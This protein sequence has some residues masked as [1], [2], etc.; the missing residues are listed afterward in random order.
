MAQQSIDV[1]KY[2]KRAQAE[3]YFRRLFVGFDQFLNVLGG[4]SLDETISS[5]MQRW[6]LRA[7]GHGRAKR[8]I[9]KGMCA[10]LGWIQKNHDVLANIGDRARA[11]AEEQR[12]DRI[13]S[14]SGVQL[15][16]EEKQ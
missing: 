8:A 1:A 4:G 13:L 15:P 14:A 5:R 9:G 3:G 12:A 6:Q 11:Q 7:F 10:W 16:E 2:A